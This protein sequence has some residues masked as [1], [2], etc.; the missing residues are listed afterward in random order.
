MMVELFEA[1][2]IQSIDKIDALFRIK[3]E[4][5]NIV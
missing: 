1:N 2:E 3:A 4:R 5:C